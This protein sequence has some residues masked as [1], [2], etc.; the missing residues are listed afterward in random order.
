[1]E[2]AFEAERKGMNKG[3]RSWNRLDICRRLF[4]HSTSIY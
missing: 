3:T 1:M 4:T 2:K